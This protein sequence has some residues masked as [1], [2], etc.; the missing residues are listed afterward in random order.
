MTMVREIKQ[1]TQAELLMQTP[2]T[3][4]KQHPPIIQ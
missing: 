1:M 3:K 2:C 4:A